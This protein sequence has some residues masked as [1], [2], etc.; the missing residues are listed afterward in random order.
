MAN[1]A[2]AP[3]GTIV[4]N[5]PALSHGHPDYAEVLAAFAAGLCRRIGGADLPRH[6]LL[7]H[8]MPPGHTRP[9]A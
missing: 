1:A 4:E 6:L 9:I 3:A 7:R 5:H 8:V 2:I